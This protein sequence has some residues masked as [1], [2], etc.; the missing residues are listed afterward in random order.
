M[1]VEAVKYHVGKNGP[2]ECNARKR[3]CRYGSKDDPK[4]HYDTMEEAVMAYEER[5]QEESISTITSEKG[6]V[7]KPENE[8]IPEEE[9][10]ID[11]DKPIKYSFLEDFEDLDEK[12]KADFD[13]FPT[14]FANANV[15][16]KSFGYIEQTIDRALEDQSSFLRLQMMPQPNLG[17][18]AA[19]LSMVSSSVKDMAL[20]GEELDKVFKNYGFDSVVE[21]PKGDSAIYMGKGATRAWLANKDG[22]QYV[23]L[24]SSVSSKNLRMHRSRYYKN[25]DTGFDG[26]RGFLLA[27]VRTLAGA[28]RVKRKTGIDM[29]ENVHTPA[30]AEDSHRM[31]SPEY[32]KN[33]KELRVK[34]SHDLV[35]AAIFLEHAQKEQSNWMAQRRYIKESS[36]QI[37]T[38]FMDKKNPDKTRQKMMKETTLK[39]HFSHVEIDNDVSP[40]EFADFERTWQDTVSKLPKVPGGKQPSLRLRKLGKHRAN[41]LY[42]PGH[43]T[44]AIDVRTSEAMVHEMGHYYDFATLGVGSSKNSFSNIVNTYGSKIQGPPH[45]SDSKISSYYKTPTEVLARGFEIY[46]HEKLGVRGRVLKPEKFENFDYAPF[47]KDPGLKKELFSFFDESFKD[48]F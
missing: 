25:E 16:G 21:V 10:I 7:S 5:M 46:A 34:Q 24:N 2:A 35:K 23:I 29:A 39:K 32:R 13:G 1:S 17:V 40:E 30:R 26:T 48:S 12:F 15:R 11:E 27:D 38:A 36:G 31:Q 33:L 8:V 6:T 18:A 37:A 43:N 44:V 20:T 4:A 41:G 45:I 22:Q 9:A 14:R 19:R 42:S 3:A 28:V 47:Q